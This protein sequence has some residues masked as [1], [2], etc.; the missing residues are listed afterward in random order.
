MGTW[1]A[2]YTGPQ[3]GC[4]LIIRLRFRGAFKP[5][6]TLFEVYNRYMQMFTGP[7][8][9]LTAIIIANLQQSCAHLHAFIHSI[10]SPST[11]D[12]VLSLNHNDSC[13]SNNNISTCGTPGKAQS[14]SAG[15][16]DWLATRFKTV[17]PSQFELHQPFISSCK[18]TIFPN[19]TSW[20]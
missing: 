5:W 14:L 20:I 18:R 11:I 1:H 6:G 17:Q 9:L 12:L 10:W 16:Q 13:D 19:R 8:V 3:G 2:Q 4:D 15:D 7:D